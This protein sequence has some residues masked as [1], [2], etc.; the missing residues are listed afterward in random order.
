MPEYDAI[1][2]GAGPAGCAAAYDLAAA[3]RSVL[4]LD[5]CH[6]PRLKPC[7]GALTVKSLKALR[8][9]IA[10]VIRE[11]CTRSAI[12]KDSRTCRMFEGRQPFCIMT[13]RSE[14]DHFCLGRTIAAGA[15]FRSVEN[16]TDIY[17]S[18]DS[19][20][21]HTSEGPLTAK[22]LVGADGANSRVRRFVPGADGLYQG[23]ALEVNVPRNGEALHMQFDFGVVDGGY[24]WI[25]PKR[26]HYNL[27][28]Y[29]SR[30]DVRITRSDVRA[31]A[32]RRMGYEVSGEVIGHKVGFG[33]WNCEPCSR[34]I[35]LVGDAAGLVDSLLGEGIYNA[36]VSGQA[37][38]RAINDELTRGVS[39]PN[40]FRARLK[41]IQH[42]AQLCFRAAR[43]FY[44]DVERGYAAL[45]SPIIRYSLIK[46]YSMGLTF[47]SMKNWFFT[48][49]LRRIRRVDHLL[50]I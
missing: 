17:E 5:R 28:L 46:G 9:S 33:G 35:F 15:Q 14:F 47:G 1:I 24:G 34:R 26:D 10:P 16:W 36:I 11:V 27:G 45:T 32:I 21:I 13:V 23:L 4:L 6:F 50:K 43:R 8:Y 20:S 49:P 38:A 40:T 3:G 12:L 44:G 7:A 25:F 31:Y 39:A 41:P 19:V 18:G 2:V 37:A 30:S 22:F 42:D 48:L 29:T